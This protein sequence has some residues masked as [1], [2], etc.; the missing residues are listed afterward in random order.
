MSSRSV[1]VTISTVYRGV[2]SKIQDGRVKRGA[3]YSV[4]GKGESRAYRNLFPSDRAT[5][6]SEGPF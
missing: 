2:V 5:L 4:V 3:L 1:L 6:Q